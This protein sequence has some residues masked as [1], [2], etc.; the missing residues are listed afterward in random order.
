M[1][2]ELYRPW[3]AHYDAFVP[4]ATEIWNKPLYAMLD[5]AADAYPHRNALIFQNTRI[6]YKNLRERAELFAGALKRIGVEPGQRVAIMLP[7]LPQ[8]MIAFWGVMK[9]GAVV[10]MTNPLYMEKEILANMQDSGAEHMVLLDLL[11]PRVAA[12][13]DRLPLRNF[14]VTGAADA[15]SFPLNW[16]YR[17]KEARHARDPIPYDGKHVFAWKS[18]CKGAQRH[19]APVADPLGDPAMLQYTGGTTGLPKGVILTHANLGTNCRQVLDIINISAETHHTF[20]SL[21]PF[22]HVYGLTTGLIIPMALASTTLPLPRYVP[23]DVLRLIARHKPTVFPGAPSVYISLLQ[24][25]N[26]AEFDL[27]SIQICVSGSAPLPREVFRRFQEATGSSI[28][29]G[30]GLTEA[31]PITHC[32]PL[33]RQGQKANSIGM[34][35]PGTDA[36]IVDMEGGSLTLPPGKMGELIVQG[37][38]IMSGYWRRPDETASALRNGW[39]YTGDLATMDE[40]GYF[41]IVDRK[42]DMVIVGGYN[43]YPREVDEALLEH[44]KVE[45]AVSVGI[46]DHIRGEVLKAYV[47]PR[48]GEELTK[49]EIIAW[50]RQKLASY[51]VP[52]LVEFRRELPRTIVGKVLRR[53]LREEEE[54]K[55]ARRRKRSGQPAAQDCD[56]E[57]GEEPTGHA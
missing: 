24:Q 29:E 17:L 10:V 57:P 55:I 52:R 45:E 16:L 36:R 27:K 20:I 11:W 46:T 12:L 53:A 25:K 31:S 39:L 22:F 30:Y 15:L 26:L 18:F 14:I 13:R 19:C 3:F 44:P 54:R 5:E 41:Y 48:S 43:V 2:T 51:K 42:K 21:L 40:D 6:T 49:A 50:C 32:N 8:T 9:A 38:Q 47:V 56:Q 28:L 33:G 23:Q 1:N 35:L 34:P 7:N 37:P 4:R